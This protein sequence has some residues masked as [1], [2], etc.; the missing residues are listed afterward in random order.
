MDLGGAGGRSRDGTSH[1]LAPAAVSSV[2][3]E[4][5][6][7]GNARGRPGNRKRK[8]RWPIGRIPPLGRERQ[9]TAGQI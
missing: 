5:S 9:G 1:L 4:Q 6:R 8:G 3:T 7:T 2:E